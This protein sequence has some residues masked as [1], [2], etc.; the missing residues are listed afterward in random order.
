MNL[1]SIMVFELCKYDIKMSAQILVILA[2]PCSRASLVAAMLGQHPEMV[3]LPDTNLFVADDVET[4][5][6]MH[7]GMGKGVSDGLLRLLAQLHEKRQSDEAINA[8]RDWLVGHGNWTTGQLLDSIYQQM[9]SRFLID[10]SPANTMSRQ[11]LDR[12]YKSYPD[13]SFL[14]LTRHPRSVSA[15][16]IDGVNAR[17]N[18]YIWKD[19]YTD[20]EQVWLQPN[21]MISEFAMSLPEGQCMRLMT[22]ELLND[23]EN[24]LVQIAQWLDLYTDKE[25]ITAMMH[26]EKMFYAKYG[27]PAAP[28]GMDADFLERPSIPTGR[29]IVSLIESSPP[30]EIEYSSETLKL[31][32]ESGYQ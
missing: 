29:D 22:E 30:S 17:E 14:H 9:G 2:A 7:S 10:A 3:A 16:Y 13:A 31:A 27:P 8:A 21:R 20:E 5:L 15:N 19:N 18:A 23:R 12:L 25:S 11:N 1:C 4:M 26:P 24:Y 32:R 6:G 28:C